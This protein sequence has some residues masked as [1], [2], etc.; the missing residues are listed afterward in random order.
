MIKIP[1][2]GWGF[3]PP[4]HDFAGDPPQPGGAAAG[5]SLLTGRPA[6]VN[7]GYLVVPSPEFDTEAPPEDDPVRRADTLRERAGAVF[8]RQRAF[9]A[10]N[11]KLDDLFT[12]EAEGP[13]W[14]TGLKRF[15]QSL[16]ELRRR[17]AADLPGPEDRAAFERHAEQFG[18]MQRIDLKRALTERQQADALSQLDGLLDY[19]TGKAATAPNDAFR[20]IAVDSGLQAIAGLRDAGYLFPEAA[21]KREMA[22]RQ[23][24]DTVDLANVV[25]GDP[26]G[27]AAIL[28][29]SRLFPNADTDLRGRLQEAAAPQALQQFLSH[30]GAFA[31]P[32]QLA[33]LLSSPAAAVTETSDKAK[34]SDAPA[35][36]TDNLDGIGVGDGEIPLN[37]SLSLDTQQAE[38]VSRDAD[39]PSAKTAEKSPDFSTAGR[40]GQRNLELAMRQGVTVHDMEDAAKLPEGLEEYQPQAEDSD[41]TIRALLKQAHAAARERGEDVILRIDP[42]TGEPQFVLRPKR[43]SAHLLPDHVP[44]ASFVN[45]LAVRLDNLARFM[46]Q[47]A[48]GAPGGTLVLGRR[49]ID[50]AKTGRV[51]DESVVS[52]S[53]AG[54][55]AKG[56]GPSPAA[57]STTTPAAQQPVITLT[58][59][60]LGDFGTDL[61]AWR[62]AASI[63]YAKIREQGPANQAVLGE[64]HFTRVG[65]NKFIHTALDADK[66]RLMPAL[67]E[68]IE[69]GKFIETKL[70]TPGRPDRIVKYH[71]LE[72]TLSLDGKTLRVGVHIAEDAYGKKFYNL[73]PDLDA[74]ATAHPQGVVAPAISGGG[75][76]LFI[77]NAEG[78]EVASE[79]N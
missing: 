12:S 1:E 34:V 30:P 28:D 59:K 42:G 64:V 68:I 62:K 24:L 29:D 15:D 74:W 76:N 14:S 33:Q 31:D 52:M 46:G 56:A 77:L 58:G 26:Q 57:P 48:G 19:Y 70:A 78:S 41:D 50:A 18:T 25:K 60:E 79:R 71:W 32:K 61:S 7:D 20:Q 39:T 6:A 72:T 43:S 3:D 27:S 35:A 8:Q 44:G 9:G 13:D 4:G 17:H 51:A 36:K 11:C 65:R 67:R 22:F 66:L 63:A 38:A 40:I 5:G 23:Q 55:R 16:G 69:N 49:A 45:D 53:G 21:Q 47:A 73:N 54:G 2:D 75:I 10:F 37:Q